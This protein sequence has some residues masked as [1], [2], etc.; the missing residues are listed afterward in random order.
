MP[1]KNKGKMGGPYK[2]GMKPA[3]SRGRVMK[4]GK[5]KPARKRKR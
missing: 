5:M 3:K 4:A 1:K 2:A